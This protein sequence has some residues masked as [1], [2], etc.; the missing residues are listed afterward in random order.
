MLVSEQTSTFFSYNSICGS[1]INQNDT[2]FPNYPSQLQVFR[3]RFTLVCCGFALTL[4]RC[5]KVLHSYY[6]DVLKRFELAPPAVQW[7]NTQFTGCY[8]M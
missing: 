4:S 3:S 1:L 8:M 2:P 7:L 5:N 6:T